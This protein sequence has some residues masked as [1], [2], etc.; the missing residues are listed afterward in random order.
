MLEDD[1]PYVGK[2]QECKKDPSKY[3]DFKVT[4]Y[5]KWVQW[6]KVFIVLVKN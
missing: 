3:V 6:K 4:G 1:Y 5:E 2:R